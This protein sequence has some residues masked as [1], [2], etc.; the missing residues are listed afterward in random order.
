MVDYRADAYAALILEQLAG[1][2]SNGEGN[3]R[4]GAAG[5]RQAQDRGN[6]GGP[7]HR[8]ALSAAA[9]RAT[10]SVEAVAE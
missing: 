3:N 5:E 8:I 2:S 1:R 9:R 4:P 7:Q 6:H 10:A